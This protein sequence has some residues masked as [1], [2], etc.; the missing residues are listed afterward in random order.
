MMLIYSAIKV[1]VKSITNSFLYMQILGYPL[2]SVRAGMT[3]RKRKSGSSCDEILGHWR[4]SCWDLPKTISQ[5]KERLHRK[6]FGETLHG[7]GGKRKQLEPS[8][9][10]ERYFAVRMAVPLNFGGN[11]GLLVRI[12]RTTGKLRGKIVFERQLRVDLDQ[13]KNLH[14]F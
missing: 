3:Q 8:E 13:V 1:K 12:Q 7:S 9:A 2:F 14:I 11:S 4:A 5:R 6:N 10:T